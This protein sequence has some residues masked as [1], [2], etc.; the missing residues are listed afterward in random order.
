MSRGIDNNTN[1]MSRGVD[2]PRHGVLAAL[3]RL[4]HGQLRGVHAGLLRDVRVDFAAALR[5]VALAPAL[6]QGQLLP[7]QHWQCGG[8]QE[9]RCWIRNPVCF[10]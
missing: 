4:D 10:M 3:R 1:C 6:Q 5:R 2:R 9:D 7:L 8:L